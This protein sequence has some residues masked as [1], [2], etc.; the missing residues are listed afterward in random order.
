MELRQLRYFVAIVDHGSLSRAAL[1]LHVAQPALT[2]QLRQLEDPQQC[3]PRGQFALHHRHLP[4]NLL[5]LGR[6]P[7]RH[8]W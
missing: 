8:E 6:R 2:Q 1:I 5:I 7:L 3:E 4:L